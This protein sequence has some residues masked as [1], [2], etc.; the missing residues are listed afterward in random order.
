MHTAPARSGPPTRL[1]SFR[2]LWNKLEAE[3][4]GDDLE[5]GIGPQAAS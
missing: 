3:L 4:A 2:T 1:K 5:N